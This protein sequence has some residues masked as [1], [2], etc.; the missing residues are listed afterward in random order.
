MHVVRIRGTEQKPGQGWPGKSA[1]SDV[2]TKPADLS[3]RL[4]KNSVN[5]GE[6]SV[7][8]RGRRDFG[9]EIIFHLVDTFSKGEALEMRDTDWCA[10]LLFGLLDGLFD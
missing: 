6:E 9:G 10:N 1:L 4:C 5:S 2:T 7:G 8:A 3:N